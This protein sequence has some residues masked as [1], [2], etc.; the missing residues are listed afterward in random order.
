MSERQI[1]WSK[2]SRDAESHLIR[3][4]PA[5][6]NVFRVNMQTIPIHADSN[7]THSSAGI[8][9]ACPEFPNPMQQSGKDCIRQ[10]ASARTVS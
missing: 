8:G 4:F 7:T 6:L 5:T 2:S 3:D 1:I 10:E 9:N